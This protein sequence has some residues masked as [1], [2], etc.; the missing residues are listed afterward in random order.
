M[1]SWKLQIN[2]S[3]HWTHHHWQAGVS[4]VQGP[5]LAA[6]PLVIHATSITNTD[7][8]IESTA[9]KCH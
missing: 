8:I 6:G 5:V 2:Q 1:V 3:H 9:R 4:E 7:F